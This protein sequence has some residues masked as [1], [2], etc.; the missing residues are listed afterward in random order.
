MDYPLL[1][2]IWCTF[3]RQHCILHTGFYMLDISSLRLHKSQADTDLDMFYCRD[4]M[5]VCL[6]D[7]TFNIL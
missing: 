4:K 1:D 7:R 5:I 3:L 2:H 6:R